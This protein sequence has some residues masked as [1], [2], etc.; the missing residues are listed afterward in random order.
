VIIKNNG[1]FT[2]VI[3][4]ISDILLKCPSEVLRRYEQLQKVAMETQEKQ[5]NV[6]L[7]TR[8]H[9]ANHSQYLVRSRF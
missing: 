8:F 1:V 2:V 7:A 5:T 6:I 9:Q 4:D 3:A